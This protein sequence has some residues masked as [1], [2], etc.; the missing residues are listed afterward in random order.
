MAVDGFA[1]PPTAAGQPCGLRFFA[2]MS[3]VMLNVFPFVRIYIYYIYIIYIA[4]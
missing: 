1:S 4:I 2:A 3:Y